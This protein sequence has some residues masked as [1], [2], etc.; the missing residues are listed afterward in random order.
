MTTQ[1]NNLLKTIDNELGTGAHSLNTSVYLRNEIVNACQNS[2]DNDSKDIAIESIV[3]S[4]ETLN[5]ILSTVEN[6]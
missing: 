4:I 3:R 2:D 6:T 1:L 5:R